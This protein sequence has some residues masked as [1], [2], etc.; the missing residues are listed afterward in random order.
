MVT[1][2]VCVSVCETGKLNQHRVHGMAWRGVAWVWLL[3]FSSVVVFDYSPF[4]K[5]AWMDGWMDD[6]TLLFFMQACMHTYKTWL[7]WLASC[8]PCHTG[9][10]QLASEC[11]NEC[12]YED[13]KIL[14]L[15]SLTM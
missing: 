6:W 1:A 7:G 5:A 12:K 15:V 3:L 14:L 11:M 8:N 10:H 4:L 2:C 9:W 13:V